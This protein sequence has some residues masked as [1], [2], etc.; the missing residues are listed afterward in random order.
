ASLTP[1]GIANTSL[2]CNGPPAAPDNTAPPAP[3]GLTATAG[4]TQVTLNWAAT[5]G[6]TSYTVK[7]GT[8][9]GGPY[10]TFTQSGIT[11]TSY[12]KTG[13]SNGTTV[14]FVVSASNTFG[15]SPNSSQASATPIALAPISNMVVYDNLPAGCVA[16]NCH[17]D[18]W[19]IQTNLQVGNLAF[20]DRS[21]TID[22][23]PAGGAGLLGK[24]WIRPAADSKKYPSSPLVSFTVG[25]SFVYLLVD[26]RQNV[27]GKPPFLDATWSDQGYDVTIREGATI[28]YPYS[29]WR[30]SVTAGTTV[31]LPG[32]GMISPT[33]LTVVP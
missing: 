15:E 9:S 23:I 20:G 2:I 14:H 16:P 22:A 8:T 33:Y 11:G 31:S 32:V 3:T 1:T 10:T 26:N 19:S 6:A 5:G 29:V 24:T 7:M 28:T 17:K 13:L 12:T 27:S 4:N 25:G 18:K 30:K 21:Y